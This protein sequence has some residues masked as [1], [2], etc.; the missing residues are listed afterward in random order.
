[1]TKWIQ[2]H[3]VDPLLM[4]NRYARTTAFWW[5]ISDVYYNAMLLLAVILRVRDLNKPL[6][7]SSTL[8]C[9]VYSVS[10]VLWMWIS[11]TVSYGSKNLVIILQFKAFLNPVMCL[12]AVINFYISIDLDFKERHWGV[13][14][15]RCS[16]DGEGVCLTGAIQKR[17]PGLSQGPP[18]AV[19]IN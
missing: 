4:C 16:V 14:L 5:S 3:T 7:L 17:P 1:M 15:N 8:R 2:D 9:V 18:W 11:Q 19:V 12:L 10:L 6:N 13:G